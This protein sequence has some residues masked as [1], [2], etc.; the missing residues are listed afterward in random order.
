MLVTY[1]TQNKMTAE[2][3]SRNIVLDLCV[4]LPLFN[5]FLTAI[6]ALY[7]RMLVSW[8]VCLSVYLSVNNE[9]QQVFFELW[10]SVL[11]DSSV[12]QQLITSVV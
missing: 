6:A 1:T 7:A 2:S 10:Y 5:F 11:V 4:V 12:E 3:L 9:F 8:S